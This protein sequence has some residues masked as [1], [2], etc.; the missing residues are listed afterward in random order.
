[1]LKWTKDKKEMELESEIAKRA[2]I[3]AMKLDVQYNQ[4]T[5]IMDIDACHNNDC[6]LKLAELLNADDTNFA[7][8]VF[9]IRANIDRATG[10]LQNCFVPRYAI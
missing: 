6:P 5:A 9:G 8:D 4:M 1:M 7:H 3:M 2:V 10:K